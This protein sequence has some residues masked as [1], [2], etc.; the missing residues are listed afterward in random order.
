MKSLQNMLIAICIFSMPLPLYANPEA[1]E[2][3]KNLFS[4][5]SDYVNRISKEDFSVF[6]EGQI[7]RATVV[8]CSDSRVQSDA[9]NKN[10]V[11]DHFYISNIGNQITTAEGSVEY[12]IYHLNTPVLLIIGHSNCGAVHAA[13]G[14][15]SEELAPI[16]NELDQLKVQKE[17]SLNQNVVDN[18]NHQV[19]YAM[20]K[21][22]DKIDE[23]KLVV[24]GTIYDFRDD[25]NHGHGRLIL[26]NLNGEKD[27]VKIKQDPLLKDVNIDAVGT[28]I[29]N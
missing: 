11:N 2:F 18:V 10:P 1:N 4:T 28:P 8:S 14:N 27:P 23:G 9:Y 26:V 25:Y 17:K 13:M 5:N 29:E 24:V 12:G 15:Y 19:E 16:R 20:L 3:L 22:K 21:F 7:P 6:K